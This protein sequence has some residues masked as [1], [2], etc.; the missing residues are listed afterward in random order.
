[1]SDSEPA[2]TNDDLCQILDEARFA[3]IYGLKLHSFGNGE[4]ALKL[5]FQEQLERPGG[6]VSGSV[7][8]AAADA[9]MWLAIMT[10]LGKDAMT[11]TS[12]MTTAFLSSAK[13]EDVVCTAKVLRLGKKLI[14]GVA[15]CTSDAGALISHHTIT[16]TRLD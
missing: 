12:G 4:C 13:K 10:R 6:I 15:E 2:I 5:P 11:V 9:A 14:Y 16:Y 7:L 1:M 3:R 8:M